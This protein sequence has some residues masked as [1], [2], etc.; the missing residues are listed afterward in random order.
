MPKEACGALDELDRIP[1]SGQRFDCIGLAKRGEIEIDDDLI[2]FGR[3]DLNRGRAG[4]EGF[5]Q[6]LELNSGADEA[7]ATIPANIVGFPCI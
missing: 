1:P 2:A 6:E 7:T 5:G 3:F 4:I